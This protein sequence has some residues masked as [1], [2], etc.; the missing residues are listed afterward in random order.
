MLAAL[1]NNFRR[2][3]ASCELKNNEGV[4][5]L[6]G[7]RRVAEYAS[8]EL[9]NKEVV[10][11]ALKNN[12]A[13]LQYASGELK[14]NEKVVLAAVK[15]DFRALQYASGELKNTEEVVLAAVENDFRALQYAS[16]KVVMAAVK[17]DFRALEYAPDQYKADRDVVLAAASA[18]D[19]ADIDG[20]FKLVDESLH[21]D[22]DFLRIVGLAGGFW[23]AWSY[24]GQVRMYANHEFMISAMKRDF[25][26][27]EEVTTLA[28]KERKTLSMTGMACNLMSN[29]DFIA[30]ALEH[31]RDEAL[32]HIS[33]DL[34][35]T[36][37]DPVMEEGS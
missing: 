6:E 1:K 24:V 13:A 12:G 36:F 18:W 10:L 25:E 3:S 27:F 19:P 9:K 33:D 32:E 31:H 17:K 23:Q 14:N 4:C 37:F 15:K 34:R 28:D 26:I 35:R 30:A 8:G 29:R 11:A 21:D 20:L 16:G 22:S 7:K 5:R 2:S